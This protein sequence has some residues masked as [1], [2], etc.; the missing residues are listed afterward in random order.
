L[1]AHY[2]AQWLGRAG[3]AFI[4]P[5]PDYS[6]TS[7]NWERRILGFATNLLPGGVRLGLAIPEL[8]FVFL[9]RAGERLAAY[10]LDGQTDRDVRHWIGGQLAAHGL[11]SGHI[12]QV[13]P[14]EI[15]PHPIASGGAYGPG[16]VAEELRSLGIWFDEAHSALDGIGQR[17]R[18]RSLDVS[19]VRCWP[20][21]FDMAT[22]ISLDGVK[23]EEGRSINAGLSP[24]DGHYDEPYYYVSPYPYP[25]PAKLRRLPF[26]HWHT[27]DFIAA[28]AMVSEFPGGANR[29]RAAEEF[30]N[31]A[32]EASMKAL[33][34]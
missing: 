2:A 28:I 21:H 5:E 27:G 3:G 11:D 29:R 1:Q 25:D 6:H 9:D 26:G 20:H 7:M 4:R 31:E 13:A 15:A 18:A 23:G 16:D 17:V 14:Y 8:A 32:V 34:R 33:G 19:P 22:L 10:A 12:D 24:G 30:I